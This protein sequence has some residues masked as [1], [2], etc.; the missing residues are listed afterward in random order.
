VGDWKIIHSKINLY[1]NFILPT[2]VITS[3]LLDQSLESKNCNGP[4]QKY[5]ASKPADNQSRYE[6]GQ[7]RCTKCGIFMMWAGI[8]CPC[9]GF[10]LRTKSH[11]SKGK[12]QESAI[13]NRERIAY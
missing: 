12:R 1:H 4:C 5:R 7:R 8:W 6:L 2:D 10:R 3:F 11:S 13:L 9:C